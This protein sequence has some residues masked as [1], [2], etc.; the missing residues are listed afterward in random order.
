M[1]RF[2][3]WRERSGVAGC[4]VF[5][6]T[7]GWRAV[8]RDS[9]I[10]IAMLHGYAP[11]GRPHGDRTMPPLQAAQ[12]VLPVLLVFGGLWADP[13]SRAK[14]SYGHAHGWYGERFLGPWNRRR[15]SHRALLARPHT[16]AHDKQRHLTA[17]TLTR[18]GGFCLARAALRSMSPALTRERMGGSFRRLSTHPACA[19]AGRTNG[20]AWNPAPRDARW[21]WSRRAVSPPLSRLRMR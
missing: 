15:H 19:E 13:L 11:S 8:V 17:S 1:T 16:R 6:A 4:H 7:C 14:E 18:G 20:G 2:A 5:A 9:G 3:A 21:D 10:A 12:F